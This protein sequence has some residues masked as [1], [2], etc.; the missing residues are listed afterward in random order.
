MP[1]IGDACRRRV[2][3]TSRKLN[4]AEFENCAKDAVAPFDVSSGLKCPLAEVHM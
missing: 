4:T 1:K 3:R 2:G